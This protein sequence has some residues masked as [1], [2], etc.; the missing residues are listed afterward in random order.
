MKPGVK[1]MPLVQAI[2]KGQAG[3]MNSECIQGQPGPLG[4]ILWGQ[5]SVAASCLESSDL[6]SIIFADEH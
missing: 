4:Q 1:G 3:G 5:G 2:G 6:H